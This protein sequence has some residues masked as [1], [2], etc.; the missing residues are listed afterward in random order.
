[1]RPTTWKRSYYACAFPLALSATLL[2]AWAP[3]AE[4]A[5]AMSFTKLD[6]Q[7]G[8]PN[9]DVTFQSHNQKVVSNA[10]GIFATSGDAGGNAPMVLWRS[11]DGGQTF[12]AVYQ[13]NFFVNPPTIEAAKDG[14]IYLIYPESSSQTRF[15]RFTASNGFSSPTISTTFSQAGSAAKFASVYDPGRRVFYH[16]TQWGYLY[17]INE[18]GDVTSVSKQVMQSGS[19]S[20][21]SYP[22]LFLDDSGDLHYAM[23]TADNADSIPYQTI[24][25]LNSTDGAGNWKTM[26]GAGVGMPTTT[27]VGGPA[28]TITYPHEANDNTWLANMHEKGGKLHFAYKNR[29]NGAMRYV[30]FD[31]SSGAREITTD[32]WSGDSWAINSV[33]AAFASDPNDPTSPLFAV[34]GNGEGGS[35]DGNRLVALVSYD[36]GTTWSDHSRSGWYGR[37]SDPGTARAVTADGKVIGSVAA[38]NPWASTNFFQFDTGYVYFDASGSGGLQGGAGTAEGA[39]FSESA[40]ATIARVNRN[41]GGVVDSVLFKVN[42]NKTYQYTSGSSQSYGHWVVGNGNQVTHAVTA[43]GTTQ[44][45]GGQI[46]V[47]GASSMQW[48][49]A[50]LAIGGTPSMIVKEGSTN[51]FTVTDGADRTY[52]FGRLELGTGNNRLETVD[53]A[54]NLNLMFTG[55]SGDSGDVISLGAG[56]SGKSTL[57]VN[58]DGAETFD[59]VITGTGNVTKSGAGTLTLTGNNG[60]SGATTVRSGILLVRHDNALG[61]AAGNT[62]VEDGARLLLQNNVDLAEPITVEGGNH[63]HGN[64]RSESNDTLSGPITLSGQRITNKNGTAL[65]ITGGIGGSS[66]TLSKSMTVQS[67]PIELSNQL[68]LVLGT[69]T[70]DVGGNAFPKVAANYNATLKLGPNGSLPDTVEV[71]L[72]SVN[73]GTLDLNGKSQTIGRLTGSTRAIVT[74]SSAAPL[75]LTVGN[76]GGDSTYAGVLQNGAGTLALAK[77]GAGT[78]ALSGANTYTGGT[79]VSGGTLLVSNTAGS[80]TGSGAVNVAGGRLGGTGSIAGAVNV[81]SGGTLAPGASIESLS[82]GALALDNGSTFEWEYDSQNLLADLLDVDGDLDLTGTVALDVLDLAANGQPLDPDTKFTLISYSG[83]WNGG[84]FAGHADDGTF[85]HEGNLWQIDYN[86]T[87]PG[88]NGGSYGNYVTLTAVPEPGTLLLAALALVSVLGVARTSSKRERVGPQRPR[89]DPKPPGSTCWR[90]VLGCRADGQPVDH[91]QL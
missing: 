12:T 65:T 54:G 84:I 10:H 28:T 3:P 71:D 73:G 78:Q 22:H 6:D 48:N 39:N 76:G 89:N 27:D 88:L 75:T 17:G 29:S 37:L 60:Y 81:G 91:S 36:N 32:T 20:K 23:T 14:N 11:T 21:P 30:R 72:A 62:V 38:D 67:K 87:A 45:I 51:R 46:I 69:T 47:Q 8:E 90:C 52:D 55:L 41:Q 74:S 26:S 61:T 50:N 33:A 35:G 80:G 31:E 5:V 77:T 86:D 53:G 49:T 13:R 82:T 25:Y 43:A 24:R 59:G 1:M 7:S 9:T 85:T 70:L 19:S 66:G 2:I 42:S 79:T 34:G 56:G 15:Q 4:G 64:I 83:E 40:G 68:N 57:T 58:N 44:T 16:A 18:A 63:G